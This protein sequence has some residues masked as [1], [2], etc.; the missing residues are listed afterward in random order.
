[1][2]SFSFLVQSAIDE[3]MR[4][5]SHFFEYYLKI[6][7]QNGIEL[8]LP[9]INPELNPYKSTIQR[10]TFDDAFVLIS[11]DDLTDLVEGQNIVISFYNVKDHLNRNSVNVKLNG[12]N[13]GSNVTIDD[14]LL[15]IKLPGASKENK[16]NV[17]ATLDNG[18]KIESPSWDFTKIKKHSAFDYY[19][20]LTLL[21]NSNN[22]SNYSDS[23]GLDSSDE[24]A[25]IFQFT[26]LY[27]W[28]ILKNYLLF[29]SLEDSQSQKINKYYLGFLMPYFDLHLGDYSPNYSEFTVYNRSVDGVS[30]TI[31]TEL[32][33]FALTSGKISRTVNPKDISLTDTYRAFDRDHLSAKVTFGNSNSFALSLNMAKSKDKVNSLKKEAYEIS[34]SVS[35]EYLIQAKDNFVIGSDLQWHMF[36]RKFTLFAEVAMSIYNSNIIPGVMTKDSLESFIDDESPIDPEAF[37]PLIVINK[38]MEPFGFGLNNMAIK[39]GF[40]LN[41]LKNNL[42]VSYNQTGPSFYSLSST[43]II[44][45]KRI[46]RVMDN[47]ILSNNFFI[48]GGYELTSD[49]TVD[50]KD[51]TLSNQS[52]FVNFN[53]SPNNLPYFSMNFIN[54]A[55][56]DDRP[57]SLSTRIDTNSQYMQ[58]TTGYSYKFLPFAYTTSSISY[59]MGFDQDNSS[60]KLYDNKKNDIG[61]NTTFRFNDFPLTT[62]IGLNINTSNEKSTQD[63]TLKYNS[64]YLNN[65][66]ALFDN[67]LI[68]FLNFRTNMNS[69]DQ[70]ESRN[71]LFSTGT[72]YYPFKKTWLS[73]DI[74][75]KTYTED[76]PVSD[77]DYNLLI[78]RF[79]IST[80]F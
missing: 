64:F 32:F 49:N 68:P 46:I 3:V 42:T 59:G 25:G 77:K 33:R 17:S 37:E 5:D 21:A 27:K 72:K 31:K 51:F 16:L 67:K 66:Y 54:N 58:F 19:G 11:P 8:S 48:S 53:Y 50:Q 60:V 56:S 63:L 40:N 39:T 6:M 71:L 47:F 13:M 69:G 29:S 35:T 22:Y 38:N 74:S 15:I 80:S 78:S 70:N 30:A 20:N 2:N 26:G 57:D 55:N 18:Q 75:Y 73:A 34:D 61:L 14:A 12:K 62:K 36:S 10:E 65:E 1:M 43:G 28:M 9:Q 4:K 23:L 44:Q 7:N 79:L 41:I 45:D 52:Y 76:N 24:Q